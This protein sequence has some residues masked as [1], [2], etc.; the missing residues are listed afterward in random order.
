MTLSR[1]LGDGRINLE[2]QRKRAKELLRQWRREP[3]SRTWPPGQEPRLEL[4]E[5]DRVPGVE[6]FVGIGQLAPELLAWLWTHRRPLGAEALALARGRRGQ[7]PRS[8]WRW[9]A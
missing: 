2:Q 1:T 6:H 5:I 4:V 9:P 7:A 8:A 3:A